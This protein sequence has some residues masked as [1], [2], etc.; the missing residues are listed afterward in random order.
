MVCIISELASNVASIQLVLPILKA[1]QITTGLPPILLMMPA[2][3][4]ASLGF[5]LPVATAPNT[6]V[7]G[8]GL[9]ELK[10]MYRVGFWLDIIGIVLIVGLSMLLI[11]LVFG[12]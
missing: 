11:P 8:T 5:M 2:T 10:A 7:F 6:I 4:A 3:L 9:I 1:L 12:G